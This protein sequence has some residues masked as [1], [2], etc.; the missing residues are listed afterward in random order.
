MIYE[1]FVSHVGTYLTNSCFLIFMLLCFVYAVGFMVADSKAWKLSH[2]PI[3]LSGIFLTWVF[4]N[5]WYELSK[6]FLDEASISSRASYFFI[7]LF[8]YLSLFFCKNIVTR[9]FCAV[10]IGSTPC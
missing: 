3:Q 7:F 5:E 1:V 8:V 4:D 6:H 10:V 2:T 9:L